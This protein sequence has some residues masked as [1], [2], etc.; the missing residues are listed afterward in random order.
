MS[1]L[2][3]FRSFIGLTDGAKRFI[4]IREGDIL[5]AESLLDFRLPDSLKEF[6]REIGYGWLGDAKFRG[7]RNLLIHPLDAVDLYK[8]E[9]EFSPPE[10]FLKGDFPI[11]D[12]GGDRFLVVRPLSENP[13]LV[14]RDE[15]GN[16]PIANDVGELMLNAL[17][18]PT[19]YLPP[20]Q[21][22]GLQY[23]NRQ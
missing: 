12:C 13:N 15:G 16:E 19:F 5:E 17:A 20:Q 2:D 8:G 6:F 4:P 14:Y 7:V 10:P 9:S 3:V 11:F 21:S 22:K 23:S 1:N 18:N